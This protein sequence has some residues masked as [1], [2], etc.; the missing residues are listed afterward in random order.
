MIF[1]IR[2]AN[3]STKYLGHLI[4]Q[5]DQVLSEAAICGFH[6]T[7]GWYEP[8]P[9]ERFGNPSEVSCARCLTRMSR[10]R[11]VQRQAQAS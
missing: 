5:Q 7:D 8:G 2:L 6:P 10:L 11:A 1:V 9:G 3:G 4:V